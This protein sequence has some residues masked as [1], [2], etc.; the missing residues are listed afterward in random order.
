MQWVKVKAKN[1][2]NIHVQC[3]RYS[4]L[5]GAQFFEA[6]LFSVLSD[7]VGSPNVVTLLIGEAADCEGSDQSCHRVG[8]RAA[9]LLLLTTNR[10]SVFR[11][12]GQEP[13]RLLRR[14]NALT[15][16]CWLVC[17]TVR[18]R[19]ARLSIVGRIETMMDATQVHWSS[20][21][22]HSTAVDWFSPSEN[23]TQQT[24]SVF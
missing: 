3:Y 20:S 4:S 22:T 10:M 24:S 21:V 8:W 13:Q 18:S 5:W 12:G 14:R 11:S 19:A 6:C 1:V 2:D 17:A 7:A 15:R 16:W 23:I 9:G